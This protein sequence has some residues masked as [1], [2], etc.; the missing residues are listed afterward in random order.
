MPLYIL[1]SGSKVS[2]LFTAASSTTFLLCFN[3]EELSSKFKTFCL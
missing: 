3:T 2:E 1:M